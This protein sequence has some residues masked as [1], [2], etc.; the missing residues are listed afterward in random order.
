MK[1]TLQAVALL[2]AFLLGW[3]VGRDDGLHEA[4]DGMPEALRPAWQSVPA[5]AVD[6]T[7]P[8]R[9]AAPE[10]DS[11]PAL[12]AYLERLCARGDRDAAAALRQTFLD[13]VLEQARAGRAR[14]AQAQL[15]EYLA[16]EP[17]DVEALLLASDLKQMEG[18]ALAAID[19][20]LFLLQVSTDADATGRARER[21]AL[22][23]GVQESQLANRGDLAALVRL[24][25]SVVERDPGYDG[26][27]IDLARWLLRSGR[28]E[29][30]ERVLRQTGTE[31]V[32]PQTRADLEEEIRL[33]RSGL[34][35]EHSAGAVHVRASRNGQPLRLLVDTGAT[36]TVLDRRRAQ[37][38][39]ATP[40][41]DLVRVRTAAGVVEAELHLVRDLQV[42]ALH[43]DSLPV[44]VID[45]PLPEGVDGLLGMD[46]IG[47]FG[48]PG[49]ALILPG[50]RAP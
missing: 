34:P 35:L 19:Q 45:H 48:G 11:L 29:E 30:A 3:W 5:G 26:H 27:R 28:A 25:E 39:A 24:F 47:R 50:A 40:T 42:G 38:L 37:A 18:Q 22:L 16:V 13:R 1:Y 46:V 8:V 20:L 31:G 10:D 32:D 15:Q 21:L 17:F 9:E 41:G 7:A 33:A 36:T 6:Q 14:Q 4:G 43:L 49:R 12:L 23:V 44:L 2:A